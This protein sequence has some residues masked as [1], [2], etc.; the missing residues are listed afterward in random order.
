MLQT[1]TPQ[2]EFGLKLLQCDINNV[3]LCQNKRNQIRNYLNAYV[4]HMCFTLFFMPQFPA[5]TLLLK[6][7]KFEALGDRVNTSLHLHR[8]SST[9]SSTI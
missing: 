4:L 6:H 9:R 2:S 7:R 3:L 1:K 8:F 5:L